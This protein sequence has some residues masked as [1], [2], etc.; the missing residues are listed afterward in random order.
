MMNNIELLAPS[1]SKESLVAAVM[2]K[3]DAVYL[4]GTK[5]SARAYASNFTDEELTEAVDY[6]HSYGVKVYITI[7]TLIKDEE[8]EEALEYAKHLYTIGV[9]ALIV[10]DTGFIHRVKRILPDFEL[11]ASTQ[12]SI[13]NGEGA[14]YF[15]EKG[16]TRMVLARELSLEEITHISRDLGIET[17]VFIHGALCISYSGQCL[18]SSIL[19]GRSGNRGRC[20]QPCRL[21]YDLLD[22]DGEKVASA[23]LM[24]PKDM[25]TI[26]FIDQVAQTGTASLKI[27]GRMKKPEYVAATVKYFREEL[28]G[29]KSPDHREKLL[30]VFN[31][32]G[33]SEGWF[34]GKTG[35]DMM[36]FTNPKNSG[37]LIGKV[38]ENGS[39][40]LEKPLKKGDGVRVGD[41]GLSV[42]PLRKGNQ[43]VDAAGKGDIVFMNSHDRL[44]TGDLYKTLDTGLMEE[45]GSTFTEKYGRKF[46]LPASLYFVPGVEATLTVTYEGKAFST[47]SRVVEVA[48]K[49]PLSLERVTE[50]LHKTS[51]T[52]FVIGEIGIEA[53]AEGFLPVSELNEMRRNVIDAVYAYKVGSYKRALPDVRMKERMTGA[54]SV[55]APADIAQEKTLPAFQKPRR[56]VSVATK[57]QL[58]AALEAGATEIAVYPFYRGERYIGFS[59]VK[60]L[61]LEKREIRVFIKVS[62]ILRTELH[63]VLKKV[64]ELAKEGEVA[65]LITNN[66][67]VIH[68][69]KDEF[70][71]IGDYKLNIF[72]SDSLDFFGKDLSMAMVSEEL[73]RKE[74]K[75]LRSK[76][77]L[78][79]LVYGRQE[80]MHSEYCPVGSTVGGMDG[81]TGCN[82]ACMTGGYAL[83]DR[84]DE[85]FPVM[86]DVFCRS[87]IMNG[88]PKNLL[89]SAKDLKS[90]G[91]T[92]FRIDLTTESEEETRE[93]VT[94]FLNEERHEVADFTRG[95]YKRG[96][97]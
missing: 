93:I 8:M 34:K 85:E 79:F 22:R 80:L 46:P 20:A 24:S 90:I 71:I 43:I 66:V 9:D 16:I 63:G 53:F 26:D 44:Q 18:M 76:D 49:A 69:L 91:L 5:F 82:E 81:K 65:G 73:N 58:H 48:K 6:C 23:Y 61:L 77:R 17:E 35:K 97:E 59:D 13:H 86:T 52:P 41:K 51:D 39:L 92:A 83:R 7:N 87:Y 74:I 84:M 67:G 19:G 96:V 75:D 57:A 60:R 27:E 47:Q 40:R 38:L 68:A 70:R 1:G 33:F 42:P 89:D 21:P 4:G 3:A 28:D 2:N 88:K 45:L 37:V 11:H 62:N 95:H 78:M 50:S 64:R 72:N 14:M 12:L 30:Q 15:R 94:A 56:L 55:T 31:R 25:T 54:P 32:E 29:R 10:Q 36:A